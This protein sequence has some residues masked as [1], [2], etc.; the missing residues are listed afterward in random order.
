LSLSLTIDFTT[1]FIECSQVKVHSY[2]L[3][4]KPITLFGVKVAIRRLEV[5][6]SRCGVNY[7]WYSIGHNCLTPRNNVY[8]PEVGYDRDLGHRFAPAAH[9]LK[10]RF[11]NNQSSN[12]YQTRKAASTHQRKTVVSVIKILAQKNTESSL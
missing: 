3:D 8:Y 5:R 1:G 9:H 7:A 4:S 10:S 12:C 6:I 2:V 11:L